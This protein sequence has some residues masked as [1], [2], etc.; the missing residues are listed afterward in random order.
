MSELPKILL[1]PVDGSES[2]LAAA[3]L[4]VQL[5]QSLKTSV[6]LLFAFPDSPIDV[7]G[8]PSESPHAEELKYFSPEAFAGLR[9][10]AA[11]KVFRQTREALGTTAVEIEEQVIPGE[12]GHAIIEHANAEAGPMIV[13]G[14]RGLG[15]LREKLLGSVSQRVLHHTTCPVTIVR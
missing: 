3:Q 14:R 4:A 15:S 5:A 12:P 10:R 7:V 11:K 2:S 13:M 9:D 8:L 6:R 1:V